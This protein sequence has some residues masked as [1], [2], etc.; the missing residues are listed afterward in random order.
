MS[1]NAL[2]L[3]RLCRLDALPRSGDAEQHAV[4]RQTHLLVQPQQPLRSLNNCAWL[5]GGAKLVEGKAEGAPARGPP[6]Q[7]QRAGFRSYNGQRDCLQH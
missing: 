6:Q 7:R 3:E 2:R 1:G 4:R 5:H